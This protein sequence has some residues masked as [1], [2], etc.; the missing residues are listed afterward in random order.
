M[1]PPALLLVLGML[2]PVAVTIGVALREN[3]P[4]GAVTQ[5]MRDP[6]VV[7]S[8]GKTLLLAVTV[9]I[10][11]WICGLLFTLAVGL[12]PRV[13]GQILFGILF[14]TFWISLLVRTYGWVLTLQPNGA[15]DTL[16]RSLGLTDAAGFGLFQTL[17]GLLP[18]MVHIMLPYMVLPIYASL[19]ALDPAQVRAARSLGGSEFLVLR[20]LVLPS[21][22]SGSWAGVLLVFIL[23]LGFY[24]TPAF[25]GGP[26]TQV[27]AMV[28]GVQFGRLE[29]IGLTAA[30]GALLLIA[31]L[32]LYAIADRIFK[33][34][35][36]WERV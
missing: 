29:N 21:L 16:G 35:E 23:S 1:L 31:V 28:I 34:S 24:V 4:V 27:L 7:H 22:R 25:L 36:Q 10:A 30:L 32:V 26:G 18:P 20:R 8:I 9:T 15:L 13:V 17:P 11:T 19:Q 3:G 2:G 6:M 12:A 14:L 5:P 33:I